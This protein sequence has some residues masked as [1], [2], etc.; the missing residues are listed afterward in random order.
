MSFAGL[1][2]SSAIIYLLIKPETQAALEN[3]ETATPAH[4]LLKAFIEKE[5]MRVRFKV[6]VSCCG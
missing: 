6:C 3:L 5:E 1:I 4:R 2:A